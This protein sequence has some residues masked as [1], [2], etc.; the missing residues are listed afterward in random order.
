HTVVFTTD[1][2]LGTFL[3]NLALLFI[4]PAASMDDPDFFLKPVGSGPFVVESFTPGDRIVLAKNE[5]YWGTP[6]KVDTLVIREIPEVS[7][8]IAALETG[9]VDL[10][11]G[12]A[13]DQLPGLLSNPDV[14]V[15]SMPSFQYFMNWFNSSREPFTDP[16]V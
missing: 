13:P 7:P 15:E 6:A 5:D 9:E 8:L 10:T 12:I 2:P 4:A 16:N 1:S 11:W 3:S 14:T